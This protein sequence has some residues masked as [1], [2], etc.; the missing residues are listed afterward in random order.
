VI[1][2]IRS[3][4]GF[5]LVELV[6]VIVLL[7][8]LSVLALSRLGNVSGFER[9][10]YYDEVV[11]ALRYAQKVALT[12]GCSVRVELNTNSYRL[13]QGTSCTAITFDRNVLN[14]ANRATAYQNLSP[15]DGVTISPAA[16]ITFTPQSTVTGLAADTV[17]SVGSLQFKVFQNTGLVDVN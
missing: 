1:L 3:R 15:P 10:A 7:S 6:T 5:T 17:F 14:P 11:N 8:V 13:R 9:R 12:T 4:F 16:S 2:S